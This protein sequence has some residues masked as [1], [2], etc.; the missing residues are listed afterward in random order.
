MESMGVKYKKAMT[1]KEKLI[2]MR[3]THHCNKMKRLGVK[4]KLEREAKAKANKDKKASY[5]T[6]RRG[7]RRR[8]WRSSAE[9]RRG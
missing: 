3:T 8:G 1:I 7:W 5:F 9:R 6:Q 2:Q 4:Y